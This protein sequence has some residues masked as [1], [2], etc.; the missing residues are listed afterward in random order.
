MTVPFWVILTVLCLCLLALF[1]A[2]LWFLARRQDDEMR[3]LVKRATKLPLGKKFRLAWRLSRDPSIPLLARMIPPALV[4]YLASPID[5]IPDFIPVVGYLDDILVLAL[6][7][8]LLVKF[9]GPATLEKHI[10]ALE[11]QAT[12]GHQGDQSRE[13]SSRAES[14]EQ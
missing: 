12:V 1:G 4:L 2:I 6:A 10:A 14:D 8:S 5:L 11:L 9:A 7:T 13:D 3:R